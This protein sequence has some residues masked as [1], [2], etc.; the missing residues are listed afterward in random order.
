LTVNI[1]KLRLEIISIE[2]MIVR[3]ITWSPPRIF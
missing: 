2:V 1:D 3:E